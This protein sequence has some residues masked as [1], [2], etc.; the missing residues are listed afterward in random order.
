MVECRQSCAAC[1]LHLGRHQ[2]PRLQFK[3]CSCQSSDP[4][5]EVFPRI[6]LN[7][8]PQMFAFCLSSYRKSL[9]VGSTPISEKV[10]NAGDRYI[11]ACVEVS[12]KTCPCLLFE[13]CFHAGMFQC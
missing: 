10:E 11:L 13:T 1:K 7:R 9:F 3:Q 8:A 4:Q 5:K 2:P 12:D 6:H